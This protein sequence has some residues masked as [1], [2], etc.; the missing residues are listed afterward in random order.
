MEKPNVIEIV[1]SV[2]AVLAAIGGAIYVGI[3]YGEQIV[4]WVKKVLKLDCA[5]GEEV[6]CCESDCECTCEKPE[7]APE[8]A[9]AEAAVEADE[10]DFEG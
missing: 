2:V 10:K 6:C 1:L 7:E 3:T 5:K 9:P 4:A 8:E